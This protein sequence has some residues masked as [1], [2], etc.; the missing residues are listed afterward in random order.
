MTELHAIVRVYRPFDVTFRRKR[1][2]K[3][4]SV[5][6]RAQEGK[7]VGKSTGQVQEEVER[8]KEYFEWLYGKSGTKTAASV[9]SSQLEKEAV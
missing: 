7:V 1:R 2:A 9:L 5:A 3:R 4:G 6:G 8:E